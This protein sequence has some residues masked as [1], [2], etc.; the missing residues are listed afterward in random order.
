M[1]PN[2]RMLV[3]GIFFILMLCAILYRL[4]DIQLIHTESFSKKGV[5]LVQE[6]VNQRTQEVVIDDGRGRFVDRNGESIQKHAEPSLVLFPFLKEI[7]WP[8]EEL[9]NIVNISSNELKGLVSDTKEP[10]V[11]SKDDGVKLTKAELLLMMLPLTKN[12]VNCRYLECLG[13]I[14]K[15]S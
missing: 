12:E 11:L 6:S 1:N 9:S 2:R 4:A 7:S 15:P 14:D 13:Y 8:A 10:V 5:N 3:L